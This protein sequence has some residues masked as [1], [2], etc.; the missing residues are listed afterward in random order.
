MNVI[1]K[2]CKTTRPL[3][4]IRKN[5]HFIIMFYYNPVISVILPYFS[6]LTGRPIVHPRNYDKRI[7]NT[8]LFHCVNTMQVKT[9]ILVNYIS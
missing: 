5:D 1:F 3:S 4:I 9:Y 6:N 8:N 2:F 7:H